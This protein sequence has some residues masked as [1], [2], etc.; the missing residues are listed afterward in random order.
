[1]NRRALLVIGAVV[2]LAAAGREIDVRYRTMVEQAACV[3]ADWTTPVRSLA[4]DGAAAV[5]GLPEHELTRRGIELRPLGE[6]H[7]EGGCIVGADPLVY[8]ERPPFRGIVPP[9]RYPVTAYRKE[10]RVGL[11]EVRFSQGRVERWELAVVA[12]QDPATLKDDEIFGY[13]VDAGTGSLMDVAGQAALRRR[14]KIDEER[15]RDTS[16]ALI[17]LFGKADNQMMFTPL[18][19][20]PANVA[21]VGSGWGDGVYATYWG[22]DAANRPVLLVTDFD[23]IDG[24]RG[25][26]SQAQP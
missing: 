17:D 1:V 20:R 16:D 5:T 8:P 18:D 24:D 7:V 12:G 9:G 22:L 6:L 21:V 25:P 26:D 10:D 13:P 4:R 3:P 19:D 14:I 11:L 2:V 15:R 23:I